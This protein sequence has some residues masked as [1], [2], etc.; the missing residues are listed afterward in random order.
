MDYLNRP[1]SNEELFMQTLSGLLC[2]GPM[3]PCVEHEDVLDVIERCQH[4]ITPIWAPQLPSKK[5]N[6]ESEVI[7][8]IEKHLKDFHK[9]VGKYHTPPM[10]LA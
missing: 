8:Y 10:K 9:F 7:R 6:N 1:V 2:V 4:H 5:Y 3:G